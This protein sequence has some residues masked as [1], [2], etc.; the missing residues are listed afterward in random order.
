MGGGTCTPVQGDFR[1]SKYHGS[2]F[3]KFEG[4][5]HGFSLSTPTG[6]ERDWIGRKGVR[7]RMCVC[8]CVCVGGGGGGVKY[9]VLWIF[10][11]KKIMVN[12]NIPGALNSGSYPPIRHCLRFAWAQKHLQNYEWSRRGRGNPDWFHAEERWWGV[13]KSNDIH[14]GMWWSDGRSRLQFRA[15]VQNVFMISRKKS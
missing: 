2:R 15:V 12:G 6:S 8:V 7:R 5:T 3:L 9:K 13:A 11:C 1:K 4:A 10:P 14:T